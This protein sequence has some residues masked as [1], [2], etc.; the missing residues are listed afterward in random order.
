MEA[1]EL[2][3]EVAAAAEITGAATV[4]V[5]V[6]VAT[7]SHLFPLFVLGDG[8]GNGGGG[9]NNG[10]N[11]GGNGGGGGWNNGGGGGCCPPGHQVKFLGGTRGSCP[12]NRYAGLVT[13]QM[14]R[15]FNGVE[16]RESDHAFTT[17]RNEQA[18]QMLQSRGY[19]PEQRSLISFL[20]VF[21]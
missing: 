4:E 1:T 6:A 11:W 8:W 15:F 17:A 3:A 9:G 5:V 19:H 2:A 14:L 10:G 21:V 13:S 20:T 16:G 7:V 12:V 18:R